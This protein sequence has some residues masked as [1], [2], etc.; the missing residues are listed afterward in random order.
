MLFV[1]SRQIQDVYRISDV[2]YLRGWQYFAERF[3]PVHA[4]R[5]REIHRRPCRVCKLRGREVL[6]SIGLRSVQRWQVLNST[7]RKSV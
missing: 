3:F 5:G 1:H 2:Y 4:V 7:R 6:Y